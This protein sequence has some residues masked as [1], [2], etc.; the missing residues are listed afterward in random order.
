MLSKERTYDLIDTALQNTQGYPAQVLI[1]SA[2]NGFNRFA[3]SEIH[4]NVFEDRTTLYVTVYEARK[5]STTSTC[6]L[7]DAGIAAAVKRAIANL[8]LIPDGEEQPELVSDPVVLETSLFN[9]VLHDSYDVR[10]RS[11]MLAEVF[12]TLPVEYKSYGQLSYGAHS[13]GMGNTAGMRR[14]VNGNFLRSS[15]VISDAL[16]GGAGYADMSANTPDEVDLTGT[17]AIALNKAQMNRNLLEIEPGAYTVLLEPQAVSGILGTIYRNFSGT[18]RQNRSSPF[19]ASPGE[20]VVSEKLTIVDDW[21]S[22]FVP[23]ISF[24]GQGTPRTKLTLLENGVPKGLVYD[25]ISAKKAGVVSTGHAG[26]RSP[27]HSSL[28]M[29][30]RSAGGASPSNIIVS[31]GE[32]SFKQIIAETE[33]G[34]LVTR[35]WY[36]NA[37]NPRETLLTGLTRDGLF[38]VENGQIT[39]ALHNMRFTQRIIEAFNNVEEI[40]Q[41]RKR[42]TR[43]VNGGIGSASYLPG[44]KINNFHFTG[45]TSFSA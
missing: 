12:A 21:S 17:F 10:V 28:L 11:K 25:I 23:G 39:R 24:D 3:H 9:Q 19:S 38:L 1:N 29:G 6:V 43:M 26:F 30:Y 22:P 34:V 5:A 32:K 2:A 8:S 16:G 40:S 7:S 20:R 4:Q 44:M 33:R 42:I 18:A 27:S 36:Q 15:V 35:F 41:D 13:W 37:I 14:Y 31:G 45:N